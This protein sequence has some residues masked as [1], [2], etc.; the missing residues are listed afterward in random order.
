[1]SRDDPLGR[2][3]VDVEEETEYAAA[4]R[5]LE[6]QGGDP[7]PEAQLAHGELIARSA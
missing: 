6:P 3:D 5:T 1:M 7:A 4:H 2:P